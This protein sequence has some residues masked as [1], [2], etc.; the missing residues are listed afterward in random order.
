MRLPAHI[1]AA[2]QDRAEI[3]LL[4]L[5]RLIP[6]DMKT[7]NK[8]RE[9]GELP[10]HIKGTGLV[11]RHYVCTL[12]DVEEFY[13][14]TGDACQSSRSETRPITSSISK[15]RVYA[16]PAQRKSGM[17]VTLRSSKRRGGQKQNGSLPKT[18]NQAVNR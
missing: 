8:H 11:R 13:R 5:A 16:F 15:S 6:R 7:L 10:V 12:S 9:R 3:P 4:D 14:R 17:N 2:F 1:E 18:E